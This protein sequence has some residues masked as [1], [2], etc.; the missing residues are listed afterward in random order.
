MAKAPWRGYL[1]NAAAALTPPAN[2]T[3]G[4]TAASH[5]VKKLGIDKA[6]TATSVNS[7]NIFAF[8]G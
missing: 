3:F 2:G 7:A 1:Q 4:A 8:F 6:G 5:V